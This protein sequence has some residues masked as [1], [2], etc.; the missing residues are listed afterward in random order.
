[1]IL[2]CFLLFDLEFNLYS[3]LSDVLSEQVLHC[4]TYVVRVQG[5]SEFVE[6][7]SDGNGQNASEKL[8]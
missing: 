3:H 2:A 8:Q 7:V 5:H 1:V 4:F 6:I